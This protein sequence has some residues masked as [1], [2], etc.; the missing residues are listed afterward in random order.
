MV[1]QIQNTKSLSQDEIVFLNKV[2]EG[3]DIK[4]TQD[5]EMYLNILKEG[6]EEGSSNRVYADLLESIAKFLIDIKR[7]YDEDRR[8]SNPYPEE[9]DK[10]TDRVML[11][12]LRGALL[13]G[14]APDEEVISLM[15]EY[16]KRHE[17]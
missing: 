17:S 9:I 13:A 4:D 11:V 2:F 6:E 10:A 14:Y 1:T 16:I 5:F 12:L 15:K 7:E 3:T 8:S